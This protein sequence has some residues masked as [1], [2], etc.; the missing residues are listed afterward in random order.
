MITHS[1]LTHLTVPQ[2]GKMRQV[3]SQGRQTPPDFMAKAIGVGEP[4]KSVQIAPGETYTVAEIAGAG[5]IVRIWMTIMQPVPGLPHNFN[6]ALVLRFYWDGEELPSVEVPFGAFFGVPWGKYTHYIAEPLSC[7]SGGY[8]SRFPMP[9]SNGCRIEV[10]NQA[11]APCPALFFQI[12][13]VELDEQ[14]APLRFHAQWRRENPTQDHVP[15]RVLEATGTGHFAGMHLWMQKVGRWFDPAAMVQRAQ[16]T[17]SPMGAFFP[18]AIGMGMLEG[19]ESIYVDGE[20]APSIPGTGNE[21]YFNS[22]FY[23]STGPYSAPHWG[24]TVRSYLASRCAAYRFHIDDAIPFHE[25][26]VVDI[27][28]GYT[29]QVQADY[30]SVAYWYQ[31]EPHVAFPL[32]PPLA[33]RL[34]T[35][36]GENITQFALFSS[37]VWVP[38]TL[39]GLKM[40]KKIFGKR[41]S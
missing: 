22:G 8:N 10:V 14:P 12:Q 1:H 25:S 40:L 2:P 39:V 24:C 35:P 17:G 30:S 4:G 7:T 23:F 13:Y 38:A 15:Y 33:G 6:H 41:S 34:P 20:T 32:L 28:H 19:W 9:F 31:M 16:E 37:P 27:D 18:E 21:D 29:N 3:S 11:D 26:I 5:T 36:T